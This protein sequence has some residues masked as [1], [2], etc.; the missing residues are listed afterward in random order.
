MAT[1]EWEI[2][3]TVETPYGAA[4]GADLLFNVDL[5]TVLGSEWAGRQFALNGPS[6]FSRRS[7]RANTDPVPQG[8]GDIFHERFATGYEMVFAI[9]L[10]SRFP[11]EGDEGQAAC[12]AALCEMRDFLFGHLWSLLRPPEDGGRVIWDPSCGEN[13]MM[14]AVRLLALQDPEITEQGATEYTCTLDSP[15]PYAMTHA[16]DVVALTGTMTLPNDG[17][18]EFYPVFKVNG[19]SGAWSIEDNSTGKLYLYDGSRPGASAIGGGD[20]G[21]IDMF[22]GGLIY[23]N[24]DGANLKAGVDVEAS[25]ILTVAAGGSS[26]TIN[27]ATADVLMHDAFA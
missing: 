14:D 26:Y 13:R 5:G 9:Q 11:S 20:Y 1:A 4:V 25:D 17:N 15:F 27:G 7:V 3:F 16:E 19:P 8:D 18:V 10:W 12:D 24:G 6:C 23:L 2:P 21:E 22:R